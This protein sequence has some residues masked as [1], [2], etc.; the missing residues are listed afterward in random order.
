MPL[1]T[2][3]VIPTSSRNTKKAGDS[4]ILTTVMSSQL[5]SSLENSRLLVDKLYIDGQWVSSL[6]GAT[7]DVR[8]PATDEVLGSCPESTTDDAELA[9]QAAN[10]AFGTWQHWTGRQRG[11]ILRRLFDLVVANA[12]DLSRIITA[13]NGKPKAD[14]DGEVAFAAGFLEWFAE[15]APRLYGDVIPHPSPDLRCH[16]VKR[17][18]GVCGLIT[19]WNFPLAM[20]VRKVGAALAAGCTVVIKS[21]GLTPF[22]SN[23]LAVLADRAGV[24]PGVINVLS[25]LAN[26]PQIG[27]A[28]CESPVVKKISFTGSTRVGKTLMQ[29]SSATLKKLSLELGGNAPFIVFDDADLEV[30]IRSVL[31]AKFKNT[32]QTCVCANRIYVQEGI[33]DRF[34]EGLVREVRKFRV[35]NAGADSNVTHGPLTNGTTKVEEQIRDAVEKKAK[36]LLGGSALPALGANFHEPTVLGDVIDSMLVVNEETFGPLAALL[37]FK[38]EE[39]V[40]Q[41]ANDCEVGLASYVMTQDLSRSCRISESLDYGM[42]AINTGAISDA[43]TPFGGVKHSGFGREGS[44][45]GCDDYITYKTVMTGVTS[46]L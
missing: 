30:A 2:R 14:A 45:Y 38:T 1:Q 34:S 7:F 16:V 22:A 31:V 6:S 43:A 41:R 23:A 29:Q 37:K 25:S 35:G 15:E 32:G 5:A 20:A 10:R 44:K 3:Q 12:G 40:I 46:R 39:E 42:V 18:I 26:T 27:L 11:R 13:E 17:P 28:L 36:V 9:F 33:Y 24:P 19:P 4:S 8:N 21:D